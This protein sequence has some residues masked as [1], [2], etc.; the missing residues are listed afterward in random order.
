MRLKVANEIFVIGTFPG[1]PVGLHHPHGSRRKGVVRLLWLALPNHPFSELDGGPVRFCV[2][3]DCC[4]RY[5][6]ALSERV[7][8]SVF[9]HCVSLG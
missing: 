9:F 4:G 1:D 7:A 6:A 5:G 8:N 2:H 3:V